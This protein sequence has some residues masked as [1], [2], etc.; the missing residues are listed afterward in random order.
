MQENN[1]KNPSVSAG[2]KGIAILAIL[3]VVLL[4]IAGWMWT[5]K[6]PTYVSTPEN[7]SQNIQNTAADQAQE[8]SSS[9]KIAVVG[10][11]ASQTLSPNQ[12]IISFPEKNSSTGTAASYIAD[13]VSTNADRERG[14]GG[15]TGLDQNRA[16]LFVFDSSDFYGFWMKDMNFA[17]DIIWLDK[18]GIVR[19]IERS[20]TPQ[21]YPKVY[22]PPTPVLYVLEIASGE[23]KKNN[24]EI[25]EQANFDL[26]NVRKSV[27]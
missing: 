25:G 7:T 12:T 21:T 11:D 3:F 8:A 20:L 26:K 17:I 1:Q 16:M 4:A 2:K 19:H 9:E 18:N 6:T 14:L 23:A 22:Y 15:R 24:I 27:Q 5:M 10:F 13:V